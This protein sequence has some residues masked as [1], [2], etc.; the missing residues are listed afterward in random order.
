MTD[1][2]KASLVE[3]AEAIAS[4]RTTAREVMEGCLARYRSIGSTLACFVELDADRALAAADAADRA[5]R[6]KKPLGPLHGVPLAHKDMYYR[7]GRVS[8]CGSRLRAQFHPT[9]T[10]TVLDRLDRAGAIE[11]GRLVMVEFAMGPHGYNQNYPLCR[12]PWNTDY[13]PCGSS[14]GSG[15]AVGAR[16][17]HGSLGSDTG[18]S[19]R[20][21]AA[22]SGVVGLA[23]TYGRVSRHGAMPMSYSLD[24]VG[25]LARTVRD[26]ARLLRIIA[27]A[28]QQDAS[29]F[30]VP[31]PDYEA[32]IEAP[33]P[34]P[35]IGIA[36][37]YFDR[38]VHPEVAK[39][40]EEA[41]AALGKL[42]FVVREASVP[43]D[44]LEEIGELHPMVMKA[45]GAA[46]HL[47]TMR[48]Q[49]EEYTFEVGHRLHA[50]FFIPA[51]NYIR[52]LKLRGPYLR[53]FAAAAFADVDLLLTPVIPIPVPTIAA[54]SGKRGKDYLDMVVA[55][56]RNTKVANYLG[57]PAISVP[58]GFT[59]NGLP[60]A[61]QL[62]GRPFSEHMLLRSAHR[63]QQG[64][65]W[66]TTEP[67]IAY[68]TGDPCALERPAV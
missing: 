10:A 66:H 27:G 40:I 53:A 29:T 51:A 2:S 38:K 12:N 63:Y 47:D 45:E 1:W 23:P 68:A 55:L 14:S 31:V 3:T 52:G 19:I 9:T 46:N 25:P 6:E 24:V 5:L 35:R 36:K 7:A 41:V 4:R 37:G 18:G 44:M 13:I 67:R 17:V 43:A 50:G 22:V 62:I 16:L 65:A 64:T 15:V 49:Q 26:C 59:T 58:C 32:L 33:G 56:T 11:V 39:A 34:L 21:P 61:F 48:D 57:L 8:A 20:C 28:D 54:T 60:V 30:P 42:G